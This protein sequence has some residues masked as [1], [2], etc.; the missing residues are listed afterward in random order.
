MTRAA[1]LCHWPLVYSSGAVS[2]CED[3]AELLQEDTWQN[4]ILNVLLMCDEQATFYISPKL[5]KTAYK[6]RSCA[7]QWCFNQWELCKYVMFESLTPRTVFIYLMQ[8]LLLPINGRQL[9]LYQ[10]LHASRQSRLL[11]WKTHPEPGCVFED[12]YGGLT[13]FCWIV[14]RIAWMSLAASSQ[15]NTVTSPW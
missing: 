12:H 15:D 9:H 1:I 13:V 10:R 8:M 2:C 7:H 3:P 14:S 11:F 6:S 5:I 4:T